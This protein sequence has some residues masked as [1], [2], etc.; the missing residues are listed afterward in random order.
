MHQ[1][2][3]LFHF[4]TELRC[5]LFYITKLKCLIALTHRCDWHCYKRTWIENQAHCGCFNN[6]NFT[7]KHGFLHRWMCSIK[8][9]FQL[10]TP[11]DLKTII[12]CNTR[13]LVV[14]S[15][16]LTA[17]ARSSFRNEPNNQSIVSM[18]LDAKITQFQIILRVVYS[19]AT[20]YSGPTIISTV[21]W[22]VIDMG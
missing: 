10:S 20:A 16:C 22:C 11:T 15:L 17:G 1:N 2:G 18:S 6:K 12:C 13:R 19:Q 4:Q 14:W 3:W 21:I 9:E 8:W 5:T 7:E